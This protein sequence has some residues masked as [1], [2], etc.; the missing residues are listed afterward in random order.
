MEFGTILG[1]GITE[2]DIS[3]AHRRPPTKKI[4]D[5]IIVN[6]VRRDVREDIYK[7]G[8]QLNGKLTS[9]LPYVNAEIG[10]SIPQPTKTFINDN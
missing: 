4:H 2:N 1:V 9:C 3:T 5:R 6:F 7:H 8:K 10:K